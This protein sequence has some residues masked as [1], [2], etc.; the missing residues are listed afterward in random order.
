MGFFDDEDDSFEDIVRGFFGDSNMINQS[1]ISQNGDVI[2]GE[3]EERNI[4]FIETDKNFFIVFE[5]PG[6][7]KEDVNL[8]IKGEKLIVTAFKKLSEKI[9]PYM[10]QK[11]SNGIRIVKKIPKFIKIKRYETTFSNGVLEV[12]FK[13]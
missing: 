9:A 10:A 2:S 4:D 5:L 3:Y 13:K 8:E 1:R 12:K 7:E 11:L 6:Y